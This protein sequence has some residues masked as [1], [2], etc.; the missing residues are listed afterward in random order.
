MLERRPEY[1]E[2]ALTLA[3]TTLVP[4]QQSQARPIQFHAQTNHSSRPNQHTAIM[5]VFAIAAA[6]L[7]LAAAQDINQR[8]AA[9]SSG[10][11]QITAAIGS[12]AVSASAELAS[13]QSASPSLYSSALGELSSIAADVT[14]A[15]GTA[16]A[17]APASTAKT[18]AA[19]PALGSVDT[20]ALLGAGAA[21]V[22]FAM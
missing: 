15:V 21:V 4:L 12:A 7:G 9:A 6:V 13:L 1:K 19:A 3:A 20:F 22:A 11:A 14:S 2:L 10:I 16:S 8:D 5:R 17:T 18:G